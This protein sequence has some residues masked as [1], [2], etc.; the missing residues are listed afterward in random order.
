MKGQIE[1][2][3]E[4]LERINDLKEAGEYPHERFR[5]SEGLIELLLR[6]S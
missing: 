4:K 2:S 3:Q 6:D 5:C 1:L